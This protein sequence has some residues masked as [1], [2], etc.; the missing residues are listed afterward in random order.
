MA[1]QYKG[2]V[3]PEEAW[4][5][6]SENENAVMVDVRTLAEWKCVGVADLS[7]LSKDSIYIEWVSF[8]NRAP[9]ENFINELNVAVPAKDA[10][11]YFLCRTGVRSIGA[12][13]AATEAGYNNSY[14]ILEGFE[15]GTDDQGHRGRTTG[16]QGLN[17][18]WKH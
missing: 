5:V 1:G 9:N 11:V 16:W 14:N 12:A 4:K 17:L 18:P 6:L 10:P 3:T 8:P 15:G 2:D 13:I 7:K